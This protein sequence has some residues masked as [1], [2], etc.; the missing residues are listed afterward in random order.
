MTNSQLL[1]STL[2]ERI[3]TLF[4]N[5]EQSNSPFKDIVLNGILFR[6]PLKD[7]IP[8]KN[9]YR[10]KIKVPIS[11]ESTTKYRIKTKLGIFDLYKKNNNYYFVELPNMI[12]LDK[13]IMVDF[14][15]KPQFT[16]IFYLIYHILSQ[17]TIENK[18]KLKIHDSVF[19]NLT[20]Q[21]NSNSEDIDLEINISF[22]RLVENKYS[23]R[24]LYISIFN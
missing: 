19:P 20:E 1:E 14:M 9:F 18:Y 4:S 2:N 3:K 21:F 15:A 11:Y 13:N 5:L 10:Y 17:L 23:N 12:T 22:F 6:M 16:F 8:N 24:T 7:S